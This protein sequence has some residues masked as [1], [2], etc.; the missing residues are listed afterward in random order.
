MRDAADAFGNASTIKG[1]EASI[2]LACSLS[3]P[4]PGNRCE[5]LLEVNS[6]SIQRLHRAL[7]ASL[8]LKLRHQGRAG[9]LQR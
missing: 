8:G 2:G 4:S 9:L 1:D 6:A 3:H 7:K 5:Y